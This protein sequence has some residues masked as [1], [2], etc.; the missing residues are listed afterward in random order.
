[1]EKEIIILTQRITE[2]ERILKE[3]GDRL[4]E[5]ENKIAI[6][7]SELARTKKMLENRQSN[8]EEYG[9][10]IKELEEAKNGLVE[11]VITIKILYFL[12]KSSLKH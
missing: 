7:S 3:N 6:L 8:S 4:I 2:L 9:R 5:Y 10:Q 1:M 12:N 11:R